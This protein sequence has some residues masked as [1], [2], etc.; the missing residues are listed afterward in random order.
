[1]F[2]RKFIFRS[3]GFTLIELMITVAIVAILAAVAYPSYQEHVRKGFRAAAQEHLMDIAHRQQQYFIDNRSY[4]AD[5]ATLNMT[6]SAD[7]A[8][9]YD[10]A[11]ALAAGPPPTYQITATAKGPQAADVDLGLNSAGEKT[12]VGKW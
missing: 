11:I 3:D 12:P 9:R 4:A 1:M 6:T 5:L 8:N 2:Q 7:L 10:I